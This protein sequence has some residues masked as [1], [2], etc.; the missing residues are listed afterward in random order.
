MIRRI[1]IF[2]LLVVTILACTDESKTEKLTMNNET[3][4]GLKIEKEF[5]V[6]GYVAGWNTFNSSEI[7]ANKLTH[8]N[9][10]FANITDGK[11]SYGN[12]ENDQQKIAELMGLKEMN[13]DLKILISVGG[14]T[15]SGNFSDAA[16]TD[17][18]REIFAQSALDYMLEN[19]LDGV[20]L[21][22]EYPGLP[23]A[24]NKFRAEDKENFTLL[25]K[26]LRKKLDE[27]G[28]KDSVHYLT[29]IASGGFPEYMEQTNLDKA[30]EYLD[31]V[32]IM[33]YDLH[34]GWDSTSGHHANLYKSER[35]LKG[36]S[37]HDAVKLHQEAG[38][39]NDKIIVGVAFYGRQWK[40]VNNA[41]N[42]Y[43]EQAETGGAGI[44]FHDIT[45][46]INKQGYERFWDSTAQAPFLWNKETH[47][48]ISYDDEQSIRLKK[49]YIIK[50]KLGGA[51]FWEY[52][53][54]DKG[55]LMNELSR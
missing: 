55:I 9:Y 6:I 5:K 38:V 12:K 18:T 36:L 7:Q 39:P 15:W 35:D 46:L 4:K 13:P 1:I 37:M 30:H 19:N 17:S 43:L 23:G 48:F 8:I 28:E 34:N 31:F 16:L 53:E 26:T 2:V 11:V 20:D 51:M 40:G 32:N 50:H 42:G 21:D 41:H 52:F 22:W 47:S 44:P 27:Q 33:A 14:W 45:P 10:A 24:G 25:L 3:E 29:S 49:E 54:D